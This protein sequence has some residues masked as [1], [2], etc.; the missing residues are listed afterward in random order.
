[1]NL[2]SILDKLT[3]Y[4]A[5]LVT[6]GGPSVTRWLALR[7]TEASMFLVA[8]LVA[9][10]I[11]RLVTKGDSHTG[12]LTM[13]TTVWLALITA[14]SLNQSTKLTLDAQKNGNPS[15]I[16]TPGATIKSGEGAN[17]DNPK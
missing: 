4:M 9:S 17:S 7:V 2:K 14:T 13:T 11:I 5:S 6:D 10:I 15:N 16:S 12:V 3:A 8:C 1:M